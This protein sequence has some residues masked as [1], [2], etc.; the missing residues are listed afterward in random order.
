M[1]MQ[2]DMMKEQQLLTSGTPGRATI[3]GVQDTGTMINNM[4]A[5]APVCR[6]FGD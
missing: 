6:V 4:P 5:A 3:K 1:K 2:D